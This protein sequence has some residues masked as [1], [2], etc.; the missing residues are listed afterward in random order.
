MRFLASDGSKLTRSERAAFCKRCPSG[1]RSRRALAVW[2]DR[3]T[4]ESYS[5]LRGAG[6]ATPS[7]YSPGDLQTTRAGLRPKSASISAH[8]ALNP[9]FAIGCHRSGLTGARTRGRSTEQSRS[10]SRSAH[11]QT[12]Q[13][14]LGISYGTTLKP[15]G[16][17]LACHPRGS[18]LCRTSGYRE[19]G[20]RTPSASEKGN[21][22]VEPRKYLIVELFE[23]GQQFVRGG[24][25]VA[26]PRAGRIVDGV[27]DRSARSAN[28]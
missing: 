6:S 7:A 20:A 2:H 16:D 11:H 12:A 19:T 17:A 22:T 14:P 9:L 1:M 5:V 23:R 18:A 27:H 4:R 3:V 13:V 24:G 28:A 26:D 15:R 10:A 21:L 25:V 8:S